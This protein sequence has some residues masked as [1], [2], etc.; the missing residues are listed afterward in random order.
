MLN[1]FWSILSPRESVHVRACAFVRWLPS[2]AWCMCVYSFFILQFDTSKSD[3]Q[4]K[5]TACNSKLKSYLPEFQFTDIRKGMFFGTY[6]NALSFLEEN[7]DNMPSILHIMIAW[8]V[9]GHSIYVPCILKGFPTMTVTS[10]GNGLS[11]ITPI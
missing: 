10:T 8:I 9:C 4:F 3:G 1:L 6:S 11:L 5:K 7:Q 2:P